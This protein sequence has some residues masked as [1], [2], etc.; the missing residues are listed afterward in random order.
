MDKKDFIRREIAQI[1]R[2]LKTEDFLNKLKEKNITRAFVI[3]ENGEFKLSHPDI[4]EPVKVFL[5][6]SQD[7][8]KH[9]G[10]FIGRED[11]LDSLFFAFVHDTRRGLA[12]GGLRFASY[13][14]F[15]D[16]ITDGLRLSQGMTRKNA[17]AGLWWGG[18]KGIMTLPA[19]IKTADEIKVGSE[20]RRRYFEAY[21]R[22]IASLKGIYYTAEDIGTNTD[23]MKAILSQNRFITCIPPSSGGSGNPSP[24]TA[25]GVLKAMQAAWKTISGTDDLKNVKISVQGA[26]NV[27]GSLIRYLYEAGSKIWFCDT[28]ETRI[29]NMLE[30]MPE[31]QVVKNEDIFDLDVDIFA[32]CAIGAQVN[33]LTI[34]RLKV[35]LV[36]GA[37]NNILKEPDR[38]SILL[39][40]KNILF[41]PDFLCNRMGIV[42]C[43]DEWLGYLEEDIKLASERVYPD[44]LRVFKYSK[45]RS[46]TSMKAAIDL[47][48]IAA[49]E[50]HPLLLHRGRRISDELIKSGWHNNK[51][52]NTKKPELAF[53]HTIDENDITLNWERN[54]YF[55]GDDISIASSFISGASSPDLSSFLHPLLAD[56]RARYYQEKGFDNP[57]SY[58]FNRKPK[59]IMGLN[60]GGLSLQIA[61]EENLPYEREEIG[62][63]R[64]L[65]ICD[66]KFNK[67]SEEIRN[68]LHYS[69][70]GF[71]QD[72][73]VNP[74][75]EKGKTTIKALYNYLKASDLI[76]RDHK[77]FNYCPSCQSII[78]AS[79]TKRGEINVENKYSINFKSDNGE[80]ITTK[81]FFPE[82]CLGSVALAIN[83]NG[84]YKDLKA[85]G[86]YNF[87]NNTHIPVIYSDKIKPDAEVIVPINSPEDDI[88][89]KENNIN[90]IIEIFD[91]K[92][93]IE[94]KN[95]VFS[96]E[97]L[98]KEFLSSFENNMT[99][100]KG[101]FRADVLRCKRCETLL[102]S[103]KSEELFV[104]IS[105]GKDKLVAL[106]N[107]NSIKF[108]SEKYRDKCLSYL[109]NLDNWCISRDYWWGNQIKDA[110]KVFSTWF[111]MVA[112]TLQA[113][114]W[115]KNPK[116]N[117]IEE[118]FTDSEFLIRWILPS[119]MLS[120]MIT[121]KPAFRNIFVYENLSVLERK[122]VKVP[123]SVDT[124]YDENRF[125]FRTVKKAMHRRTGN[126]I[127]PKTIVRRFGADVLRLSYLLSINSNNEIVFSQD[128]LNR[129]HKELHSFT[130]KVTNIVSMIK[131]SGLNID[132]KNQDNDIIDIFEEIQKEAFDNYEKLDFRANADLMIKAM[133][134]FKNYCNNV[135]DKIKNGDLENSV[136][137]IVVILQKMKKAFSP[138]APYHS[139]KIDF[140]FNRQFS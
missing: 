1:L 82:Y 42:N 107:N 98:R 120:L 21:G 130:E 122:L 81:M 112:G 11:G 64:F 136:K 95:N 13:E 101:N 132:L 124:D 78:V 87:F 9:E 29:K 34:P 46:V 102:V 91:E 17:L 56:I 126:V 67:N 80:N 38:D 8:S 62:K 115:P 128:K 118:V 4:L 12:Q 32:P 108:N 54:N 103:K 3:F 35:K 79:D 134:V 111:S 57:E 69:G 53:S 6:L 63:P 37:A 14:K 140:W 24:F 119:Q 52:I 20:E 48:D 39:K 27:G 121:G 45:N 135:A 7:F 73:W 84:K 51:K 74:M 58:I 96:R 22:F 100:E 44:T 97:E 23:D 60:H 131:K 89:A 47:A 18:G 138:I 70:I 15:A 86:V 59:R 83:K 85:N 66:D 129:A 110:N 55:E 117:T 49:S 16:V 43:A 123:D 99:S 31:L 25:R 125:L 2:D 19:N 114:D 26:G 65:E 61:I 5:E 28:S 104:D 93:H 50:L 137:T 30:E 88:I 41:V 133:I 75:S 10:I 113:S 116:A 36:C 139:E 33:S 127:E 71:S 68:Q 76:K 90:E 72:Y 109:N 92:G 40:E 105:E 77:L 106:I 94:Y